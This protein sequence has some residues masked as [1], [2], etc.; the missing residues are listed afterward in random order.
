MGPTAA[1]AAAAA[2]AAAALLCANDRLITLYEQQE[3]QTCHTGP[4]S[5]RGIRAVPV[6][7][8]VLA[9]V[10]WTSSIQRGPCETP[11]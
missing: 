3:Q 7:T 9:S 6:P 8:T 11:K 2:A 4:G 10:F 5:A 1:P